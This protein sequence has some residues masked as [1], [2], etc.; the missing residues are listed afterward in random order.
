MIRHS[1]STVKKA[2]TPLNVCHF[3]YFSGE[4]LLLT[5]FAQGVQT[6]WGERAASAIS[7]TILY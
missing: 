2:V 3:E 5:V 4:M 1:V 7:H 6:H